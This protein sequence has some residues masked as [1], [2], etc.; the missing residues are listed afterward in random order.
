M[1]A[2]FS[3]FVYFNRICG[4]ILYFMF[5]FIASTTSHAMD[6][7]LPV[8]AKYGTFSPSANPNIVI[9]GQIRQLTGGAQIRDSNNMIIL[10]V[11]LNGPDV[12]ILYKENNQGQIDRIWILTQDEVQKYAPGSPIWNFF[13]NRTPTTP[14]V[15]N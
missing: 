9:N 15:A 6:R 8:D 5:G 14:T 13:F 10:P 3:K 2:S 12:Q 11:A 7:P 4:L 1:R